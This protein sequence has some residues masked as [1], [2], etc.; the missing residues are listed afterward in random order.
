MNELKTK[1]GPRT[2]VSFFRAQ[3]SSMVS[4]LVDFLTVILL[5]EVFGIWYVTSNAIGALMGTI[6]NFLIGRYWVFESKERQIHQQ[7]FRYLLV[8]AGSLILNTYGVYLITEYFGINYIYSK[9]IVSI[10][11]GV[12][13]NFVLQKYFVF[14]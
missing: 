10:F 12:F 6:V 8:S 1:T 7:A 4:T 3:L 5:T 13:Y 11:I 9:V 14:K 2:L